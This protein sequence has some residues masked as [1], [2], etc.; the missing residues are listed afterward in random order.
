VAAGGASAITP[1]RLMAS[2]MTGEFLRTDSF[3]E[4]PDPVTGITKQFCS[5]TRED[6]ICLLNPYP[7]STTIQTRRASARRIGSTYA[8]DFLGVM[9]V[10]APLPPSLPPSLPP[11]LPP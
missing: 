5:I 2:S 9:E 10:G 3:L 6:Q 11:P 7:A 1:V 4:Y 8:Y